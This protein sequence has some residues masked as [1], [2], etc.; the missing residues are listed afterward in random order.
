MCMQILVLHNNFPAQFKHLLP[1]LQSQGH[2]IRFL[3]LESHGVRIKGVKHCVIK[4]TVDKS[5]QNK[6]VFLLEKKLIYP[7]C[8]MGLYQA[9]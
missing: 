7:S 8:F 1:Y 9:S 4:S 3:S 2:E 6:K 5:S